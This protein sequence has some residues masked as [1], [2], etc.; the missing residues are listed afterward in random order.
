MSALREDLSLTAEERDVL[1]GLLSFESD[2]ANRIIVTGGWF[3]HPVLASTRTCLAEK[4]TDHRGI[5]HTGPGAFAVQVAP[6]SAERAL[7][8]VT[9]LCLA[10]TIRKFPIVKDSDGTVYV[11]VWG[12]D[13]RIIVDERTK[14][15]PHKLSPE[16]RKQ[17]ELGRD[18]GSPKHDFTPKGVLHLSIAEK[19]YSA[20]RV[21]SDSRGY[22]LEDHLDK[23]M[24]ALIMTAA[25]CKSEARYRDRR[26]AE[27]AE[28]E[29]LLKA[30]KDAAAE[31]ERRR[32]RL[33]ELARQDDDSQKLRRLHDGVVKRA[34][35]EGV[36]QPQIQEWSAYVLSVAAQLD[37]VNGI[38]EGL[39]AHPR[40]AD[41]SR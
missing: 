14:Q 22:K 17:V 36:D 7:R 15:S 4:Y 3:C 31:Q 9:A 6:S 11:T 2:A 35:E 12:V 27:W 8:I 5:G 28:E 16:E 18:W 19:H 25:V 41:A 39:K 20:Y 23:F 33:L 21:L 10:F 24:R 32:L 37:S 1:A 38:V 30:R 29:R 13:L 34:G 40:T 26:A